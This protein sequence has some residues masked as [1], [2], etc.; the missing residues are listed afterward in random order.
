MNRVRYRPLLEGEIRVLQFEPSKSLSCKLYNVKL[1]ERF[2]Y[3]ALSYT[4]GEPVLSHSILVNDGLLPITENLFNALTYINSLWRGSKRCLWVDQVCVNQDDVD[5]RS[6]Q[7]RLMKSVYEGA[8]VI[9]AWLDIGEHKVESELAFGKMLKLSRLLLDAE[10]RHNGEIHLAFKTVLRE[11]EAVFDISDPVCFREWSSIRSIMQNPWWRRTWIYQEASV[12]QQE[13][14]KTWFLCGVEPVSWQHIATAINM[15]IMLN[16]IPERRTQLFFDIAF[17][18]A[19]ELMFFLNARVQSHEHEMT[20][21]NLLQKFRKTHCTDP[22]DKVYAPLNFA[23]D[24]PMTAITPDYSKAAE[25]VYVDIVKVSLNLPG[26]ELDFLGYVIRSSD[27]F[28]SEENIHK[29]LEINRSW[30]PD[31]GDHISVAPLPKTMYVQDCASG[32]TLR[33]AVYK[34]GGLLPVDALI[35]GHY[36]DIRGCHVDTIQQ[37]SGIWDGGYKASTEIGTWLPGNA[38]A[39]YFTGESLDSARHRTE[40]ADVKHD[41]MDRVCARMFTVD[42]TPMRIQGDHLTVAQKRDKLKLEFATMEACYRRRLFWTRKGYIGVG[43][44]AARVGDKIVSFFGG[45]VLYVLRD[46]REEVYEFMGECYV[47]GLMD[48]EVIEWLEKGTMCAETFRIL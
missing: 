16:D 37:L 29:P 32:E 24:V 39:T 33:A 1:K 35:N 13:N 45:Q 10:E 34:A 36:L 8:T 3:A 47:H 9:G 42:W 12:P 7:V 14:S 4:W 15:S 27:E 18:P 21:F 46:K 28:F 43:P 17:G 38:P 11:N 20:L 30:V 6:A 31:W 5:E 48:G 2:P 23:T 25:E 40:V 44:A 26:H 41:N 22:R 19:K